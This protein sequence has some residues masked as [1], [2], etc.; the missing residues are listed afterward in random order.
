MSA[1]QSMLGIEVP[2]IQAPMA[3][4]QDEVLALAVSE[5]GGLGSMPCALLSPAQ[6]PSALERLASAPRPINLNFFCHSMAAPD[7]V[8]EQRWREALAPYYE[9]FEIEAPEPTTAGARQPIDE[10]TVDL[11]E[12]YRPKV[13]SFHFGLP[14]PHLLQRMKAWGA[15]ILASATT[16]EEGRW[17]ESNGVDVVI[18]QGIEA[19]G[20]RGHFL[21]PDLACQLPARE[22]VVQLCRA[23]GVPIVAAGGVASRTD[24]EALLDA[25]ASAIQAG[26]AYLLCPEAKT[27]AVHRAALRQGS[28]DTAVTNLFSGRPARGLMNRLMRELGPLSD[29]PPAFPW[30]SQALMPLRARAEAL[31]RDDF[32]PLWSGTKPGRFR[33]VDA[34]AVTREL[35]GHGGSFG[36]P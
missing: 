7:P 12:Q 10:P 4:V 17:L 35:A 6:L 21:S 18:A 28:T 36:I 25:G 3:G 20:H 34:A 26:T 33:N 30:A 27:A 14:P 19:G 23:L 9:E 15:A 2:V 16:L 1:L 29:L 8:H 31:G 32:T 5:A 11:L 24:V 22:L 13:V